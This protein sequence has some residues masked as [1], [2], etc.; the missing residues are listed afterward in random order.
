LGAN[1]GSVVLE[2][3][4]QTAGGPHNAL[5][6]VWG[7]YQS[8]QRTQRRVP[9]DKNE[10]GVNGIVVLGSAE[11]PLFSPERLRT[12]TLEISR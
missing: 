3:T 1:L 7:F 5:F 4:A 12:K 10:G 11:T 9:L 2:S 6:V 8:L